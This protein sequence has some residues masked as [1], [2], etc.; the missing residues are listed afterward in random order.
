MEEISKGSEN[1]QLEKKLN[2]SKNDASNIYHYPYIYTNISIYIH[3]LEARLKETIEYAQETCRVMRE[4][5][6]HAIEAKWKRRHIFKHH[7]L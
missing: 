3:A 1:N 5:H 4:H 2:T 6:L 7:S